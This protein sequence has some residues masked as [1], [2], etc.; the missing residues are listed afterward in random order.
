MAT[1][2]ASA[3]WKL[4]HARKRIQ[5]RRTL[6]LSDADVVRFLSFVDQKGPDECWPWLGRCDDKDGY[7]EFSLYGEK[8]K[9]SRVAFRLHH[10]RPPKHFACHTC[11][12]PPCCNPRHL[13]DGTHSTNQRDSH[14]KGRQIQRGERNSNAKLSD[15]DV[16]DI[17]VRLARGE[18]QYAIAALYDVTQSNISHINRGK[19][20]KAA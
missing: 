9:A 13:F 11:D 19:S 20:R 6:S 3:R 18:S 5:I 17:R 15:D 14:T 8:V 2:S 1:L 4:R 10:G 12:N 7:G 16:D